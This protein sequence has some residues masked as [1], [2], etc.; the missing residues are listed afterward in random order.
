MQVL[1]PKCGLCDGQALNVLT[2]LKFF[3]D[4]FQE[5][6]YSD[7]IADKHCDGLVLVKYLIPL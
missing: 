5:I 7:N 3:G 1:W 4:I 6:L 2:A